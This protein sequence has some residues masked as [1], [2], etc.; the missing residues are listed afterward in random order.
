MGFLRPFGLSVVLAF[1]LAPALTPLHAGPARA[2]VPTPAPQAPAAS[3][4]P[5]SGPVTLGDGPVTD[6]PRLVWSRTHFEQG[7]NNGD[8]E[9]RFSSFVTKTVEGHQATLTVR[10]DDFSMDMPGMAGPPPDQ[11]RAMIAKVEAKAVVDRA[12]NTTEISVT[13]GD[14]GPVTASV[15]KFA[16]V[17][18]KGMFSGKTLT[19]GQQVLSY[20]SEDLGTGAGTGMA[21]NVNGHVAGGA[22]GGGRDYVVI[23]G[24]G[25]AVA[26][27]RQIGA[28]AFVSYVDRITG[29]PAWTHT[30]LTMDIPDAQNPMKMDMEQIDEVMILE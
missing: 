3:V 19:Q 24:E 5:L 30:T 21:M 7:E 10:G 26:Q 1:S 15:E 20:D 6:A 2:E 9:I 28:V 8:M 23:S 25:P 18:A 22:S 4:V 27:G 11:I 29:L 13:G 12:K 14:G 16:Q 17:L